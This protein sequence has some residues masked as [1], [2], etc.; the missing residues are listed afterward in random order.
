M[1]W[2]SQGQLLVCTWPGR[3]IEKGELLSESSINQREQN[4]PLHSTKGD[5]VIFNQ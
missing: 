1:E 3:M 2:R 4:P 5:L